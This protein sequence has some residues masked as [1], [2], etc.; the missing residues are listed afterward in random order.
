MGKG[1]DPS[2][3]DFRM[4]TK[5][6]SPDHQPTDRGSRSGAKRCIVTDDLQLIDHSTAKAAGIKGQ[7][8]QSKHEAKLYIG[9]EVARRA[10]R[11]RPLPGKDRWRQVK[12]PLFAVRPDGLKEIVAHL[13]LDF[14]Y[15]WKDGGDR[16]VA[17]YEDAKPSGGHR[18]DVY[19]LK[20]RWWETQYGLR[21]NEI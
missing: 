12:F 11:L 16:W 3:R 19:L 21:I 17:H 10:G 18:E 2:W 7:F 13:V 15:E 5:N 14:S 1:W 6:P 9:L 4:P 20:K 8:F